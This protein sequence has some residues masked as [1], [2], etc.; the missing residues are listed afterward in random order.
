MTA[1]HRHPAAL[2]RRSA[3]Q[4]IVLPV[5]GDDPVV[6]SPTGAAIWDALGD[7]RTVDELTAVLKATFDGERQQIRADLVPFLEQL[8]RQ[9]MVT[10]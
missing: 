9:G 4:V 5:Q 10:R 8:E 7:P 2:W 6:L 3:D 1:W